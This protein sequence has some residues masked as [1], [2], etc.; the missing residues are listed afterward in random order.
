M[1]LLTR[2]GTTELAVGPLAVDDGVVVVDFRG[3]P[4]KV[5][6][7]V[8]VGALVEQ[9]ALV[10]EGEHARTGLL[11]TAQSLAFGFLKKPQKLQFHNIK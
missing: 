10:D 5:D 11:R 3:A 4:D 7:G 1:L 8:D 6:L 9:L 2:S